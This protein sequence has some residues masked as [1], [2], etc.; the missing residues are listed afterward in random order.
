MKKGGEC[1]S[2]SLAVILFKKIGFIISTKE[3]NEL[4]PR[5]KNK[6]EENN[7]R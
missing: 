1:S 7:N 6:K 2:V 4:K 3:K 5:K